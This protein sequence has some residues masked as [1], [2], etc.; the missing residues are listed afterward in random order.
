V[1]T[2]TRV[3]PSSS[4]SLRLRS[5]P[6]TRLARV[7]THLFYSACARAYRRSDPIRP[8]GICLIGRDYVLLRVS[9]SR[10]AR[11]C[12]SSMIVSSFSRKDTREHLAISRPPRRQEPRG[13]RP[14]GCWLVLRR[15]QRARS[16]GDRMGY[17]RWVM[18]G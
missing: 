6:R 14:R 5:R 13:A 16:L 4:I 8:C 17:V 12:S 2:L 18:G 3:V 11:T 1:P 15:V 9:S 7:R 10:F